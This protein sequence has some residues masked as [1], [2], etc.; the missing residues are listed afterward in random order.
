[1]IHNLG[2][3]AAICKGLGISIPFMLMI[4]IFIKEYN[5][6]ILDCQE[7]SFETGQAFGSS[8]FKQMNSILKEESNPHSS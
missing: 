4:T 1:M 8:K 5:G 7:F 2:I 3:R 6:F